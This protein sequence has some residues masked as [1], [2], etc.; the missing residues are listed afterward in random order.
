[1]LALTDPNLIDRNILDGIYAI[2]IEH[3]MDE[4]GIDDGLEEDDIATAMPFRE[5]A[6]HPSEAGAKAS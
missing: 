1:L 2:A 6:D 5:P 4:L 3:R